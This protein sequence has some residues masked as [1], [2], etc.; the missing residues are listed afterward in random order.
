[1]T[2]QVKR[3]KLLR[4]DKLMCGVGTERTRRFNSRSRELLKLKSPD[5]PRKKKQPVSVSRNTMYI[6]V[7]L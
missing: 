7:M 6:S 4:Q 5:I 1:M 3:Q 2:T